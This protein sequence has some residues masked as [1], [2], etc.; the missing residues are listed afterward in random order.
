MN[1]KGKD[2]ISIIDFSKTEINYI[3]K[4]AKK[5]TPDKIFILSAKHGLLSLSQE[6]KPYDKTLNNMQSNEIKSGQTLL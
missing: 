5:M 3:L 4:Y 2:I 6:I 1:F